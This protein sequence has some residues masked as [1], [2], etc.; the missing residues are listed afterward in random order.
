MILTD[1]SVIKLF[2]TKAPIGRRNMPDY[3]LYNTQEECDYLLNHAIKELNLPVN[4][5]PYTITLDTQLKLEFNTIYTQLTFSHSQH[6]SKPD[7]IIYTEKGFTIFKLCISY[8]PIKHPITRLGL[9]YFILSQLGYRTTSSYLLCINPHFQID[10]NTPSFFKRF[11][12]TSKTK[13]IASKISRYLESISQQSNPHP[14]VNAKEP[15]TNLNDTHAN[16]TIPDIF[17]LIDMPYKQKAFY[18]EEGILSFH[19]ILQSLSTLSDTQRKQ[20]LVETT[21]QPFFEPSY[22][23]SFLTNLTPNI[24]FFDIEACQFPYPIFFAKTPFETFPFLFSIHSLHTDTKKEDHTIQFFYPD[25]DFRR[26][27]AESLITHLNPNQSIIIFDAT[28]ERT[29]LLELAY[30]FPDLRNK[31][32]KL[33]DQF[34]DISSL[35]LNHHIMLPGMQGKYSIKQIIHAITPTNPY[36]SL[37]IQSGFFASHH[38]KTLIYDSNADKTAIKNTISDYCKM[39]TYSLVL[40]YNYLHSLSLK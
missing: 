4:R 12:I 17:Q 6:H 40:I 32:N 35:F 20:C 31:L 27:F 19:D 7:L 13:N 2:Q 8:K 15:V 30:L 28:M 25:S 29:L 10:Q 3:A 39:D 37:T 33:L 38:Y 11:N 18:Y 23:N 5:S 36:D 24:Q 9:S 14:H 22:L 21:Q 16:T 1:D 26:E 34:V